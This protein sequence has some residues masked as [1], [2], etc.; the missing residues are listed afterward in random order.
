MSSA[1]DKK[2]LIFQRVGNAWAHGTDIN[3]AGALV[4]LTWDNRG[5]LWVA[6]HPDLVALFFHLM[7]WR[8]TSPSLVLQITEPDTPDRAIERLFSD[9]GG[10]LSAASV[11]AFYMGAKRS[12][13]LIGS[14]TSPHLLLFDLPA[15]SA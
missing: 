1:S 8:Q 5:R 14:V 9:D 6:V 11:A 4:N 10:L 2:I 12:R 15:A 7:G 3:V 13:L